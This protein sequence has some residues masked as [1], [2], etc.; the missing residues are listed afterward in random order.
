MITKSEV[1]NSAVPGIWTGIALGLADAFSRQ[2]YNVDARRIRQL[3]V[4]VLER[5]REKWV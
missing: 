5:R 1:C 2:S 3:G 4:S